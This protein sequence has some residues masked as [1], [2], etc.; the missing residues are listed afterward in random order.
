MSF[1]FFLLP[2]T[3]KWISKQ[4]IYGKMQL[5]C[6]AY[7][8]LLLLIHMYSVIGIAVWEVSRLL[9]SPMSRIWSYNLITLDHKYFFGWR[10]KQNLKPSHNTEIRYELDVFVIWEN[11]IYAVIISHSPNGSLIWKETISL[12]QSFASFSGIQFSVYKILSARPKW[13]RY[14]GIDGFRVQVIWLEI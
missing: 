8:F 2:R 13:W 14:N 1:V 5:Y 10:C 4:Y 11:C 12:R 3:L 9:G 7:Q 6:N